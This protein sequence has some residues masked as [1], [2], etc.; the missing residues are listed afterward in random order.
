MWSMEG[1]NERLK[2]A[3]AKLLLTEDCF[4]LYDEA[5]IRSRA[6]AL[7]RSFPSAKILYSLKANP[8]LSVARVMK[9][10]GFG[11]DAASAAE[12][13]LAVS[14]GMMKE[15]IQYSAPGKRAKDIRETL[16]LAT[17]VADSA[18]EIARIEEAAK[19]KGI[20]VSI[21]LRIHPS[22]GF[23]GGRG[24]PSKFGID[25]EEAITLLN[26]WHFPHLSPAGIHVHLK[27]QELSEEALALYYEN[28][29]LMAERLGRTE[30]MELSFVNLG[31]GIGIPMDPED[32]EMDLALLEKAFAALAGPFHDR[33]PKARL[34]LESGR[35]APG[36][37][38]FYVTKALDRKV[39]E[40][41]VFLIT[42]GTMHGFLR[43]ALARLVEKYDETGHPAL[44][45]PLFSGARAFPI[46]TLREGNPET[47]TITGNL[48]TAADIIAEDITLPRLAEGDGIVIGNAGAYAATLSPF[49]FSSLERP[50]EFLLKE[51]GDLEG[52]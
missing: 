21:G 9:E 13:R 39:S 35:Y 10:E 19:E 41:K 18:G 52:V 36:P 17:L 16:E 22:F 51:T 40:G 1:M 8:F 20:H 27:S 37:S 45:E 6:R 32:E 11:A 42:A 49:A 34:F 3:A 48:C 14:L 46:S 44:C 7:T 24:E 15:E 50:K 12:V 4:Y 2:A 5:G 30:A 33:F 31:S 47:V 43:P 26:D 25:E 23:A 38:G 28:V 29:L